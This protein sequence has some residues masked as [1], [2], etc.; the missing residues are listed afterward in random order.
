MTTYNVDWN[1]G[2]R[3]Q[4][5]NFNP[6]VDTVNLGW[7]K[8]SQF[9]IVEKNGSVYISVVGNNNVMT[10]NGVSLSD[11]NNSN[12]NMSDSSAQNKWNA[13]TSGTNV[14]VMDLSLGDDNPL[15]I[16]NQAEGVMNQDGTLRTIYS[17]T[18]ENVSPVNYNTYKTDA[19]LYDTLY[20][21][22]NAKD[23]IY[24]TA[25]NDGL[26]GYAGDDILLGGAGNDHLDGSAGKNALFGGSGDDYMFSGAGNAATNTMTG[27]TGSDHFV[28]IANKFNTNNMNT[29]IVTD[30]SDEDS[31]DIVSHE[32]SYN[33]GMF[34]TNNDG[35]L[36]TADK[37]VSIV[38][39]TDG[40]SG[41]QLAVSDNFTIQVQNHTQLSSSDLTFGK[42]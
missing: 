23:V 38:T 17:T 19:Q 14:N 35:F 24:G 37:N 33:F 36:T 31:I 20:Q 13:I 25:D 39:N 22:T 12:L 40:V 8:D 2:S 41:I 29:M 5:N 3:K 28:L 32:H 42:W 1:Y 7:L 6:E 26:R 30:F 16:K 27:G 10:L 9:N 18:A 4:I 15:F 21:G 11:L 34:D